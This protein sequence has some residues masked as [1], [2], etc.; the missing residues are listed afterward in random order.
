MARKGASASARTRSPKK[1][2]EPTGIKEVD[3]LSTLDPCRIENYIGAV[4]AYVRQQRK[5]G[6]GPKK[7]AQ[8]RLS[9]ALGRAL[10]FHLR[11]RLP[12]LGEAIVGETQVAG[13][14][15]STNADVSEIHRLD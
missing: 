12:T 9:N 2:D 7:A 1:K 8:I 5:L 11:E 3:E 4:S 14:L 13:A 15:R 10:V 6:A